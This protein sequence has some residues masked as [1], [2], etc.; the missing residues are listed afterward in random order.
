VAGS[1]LRIPLA[2]SIALLLSLPAAVGGSGAAPGSEPRARRETPGPENPRPD[3]PK[4]ATLS[5]VRA[6]PGGFLG[7]ELEVVLQLAS[8]GGAWTPWTSRFGPRDFVR[9]EAW[10]DR[11]LPWHLTDFAD[12]MRHLYVRKGSLAAFVIEHAHPHERF[13]AQVAVRELLLGEPRL[14][15]LSIERLRPAIGEGAVI[16]GSKA[17]HLAEEGRTELALSELAR[18]LSSPL[19]PHAS[20]DLERLRAEWTATGE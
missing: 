10:C 17:I 13:T 3:N 7:E 6:D 19:P 5:E 14:E 2:A 15:I 9:V 1:R 8:S 4:P 16:H 20:A 12:P 18:A 11:Q